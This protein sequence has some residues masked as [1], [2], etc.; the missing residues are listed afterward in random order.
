MITFLIK[1]VLTAY[2]VMIILLV[3]F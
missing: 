3:K 2:F 1:V